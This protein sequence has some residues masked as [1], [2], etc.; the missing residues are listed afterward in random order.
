MDAWKRQL[1]RFKFPY[2]GTRLNL[3]AAF[4]R[5]DPH[6]PSKL[7]KYRQFSET[8]LDAVRR[9]VLWM[10]SPDK[11]NDPYDSTVY[12]DPDR[13]FVDNRS[14]AEAY[15]AAEQLDSHLQSGAQ[16]RPKPITRPIR[17]SEW[18]RKTASELLEGAS[19]EM[20]D[21]VTRAIDKIVETYNQQMVE[22]MS[23]SSRE[24]Y[25]V[26]SLTE[27]PTSVLMWSHYSDDHRGFCI[28]YDFAA[29]DSMDLRRR[30]CFPVFY[31]RKLTD[32][33]R[34]LA[35]VDVG[36][37]NLFFGQFLCL[38]KS[39]EWA[40][41]KEWRIVH[42][43]GPDQ[44]N[45]ELQMPLPSAIILGAHTTPENE[46]KMRAFCKD[47][48]VLKKIIQRHNEFRLDVEELSL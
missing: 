40:Y 45:F 21:G 5:K 20:R 11:F 34:Y 42:A 14:P 48:I 17:I 24:G 15:A 46:G 28:E 12:F 2:S 6:I 16:F 31:R 1:V 37:L 32:A 19:P 8:H 39:D 7:Y 44:A 22:Q 18:R 27:V 10:S 29:L 33:T 36:D 23:R 4:S 3:E 47:R 13:L 38:L 35:K 26:L 25:S 43:L 30:L 9:G 41:E